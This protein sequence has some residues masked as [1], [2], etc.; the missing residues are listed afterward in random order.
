MK[1]LPLIALFTV[2]LPV[3]VLAGEVPQWF[4]V[5][6][7]CQTLVGT[8]LPQATPD[9]AI[10]AVLRHA[11]TSDVPITGYRIQRDPAH[12]RLTLDL[13]MDPKSVRSFASLSICEQLN[14]FGGL[15][16]TLTRYQPWQIDEVIFTDRGVPIAF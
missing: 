4:Q 2:L 6:G 8:P 9:Q 13:R 3:P 16:Q 1:T 7:Q 12:R 10:A 14:L 11:S 15:Q 5:D